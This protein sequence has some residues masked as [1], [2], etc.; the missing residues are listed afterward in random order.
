MINTIVIDDHKAFN[1]GLC[2][3]LKES[4]RFKVVEQ[5]YDSRDAYA[6]CFSLRPALVLL[7]YSMPY[8]NGL[9]VTKQ[10]KS[11]HYDCKVVII[12]MY[13]DQKEL[14]LLRDAGIDGYLTK[15]TSSDKLF[16]S[17]NRILAGEQLFLTHN[18]EKAAIKKDSL[19]ERP[20]LTKREIQV[21]KLMEENYTTTQIASALALSVYTIEI[22]Q[23]NILQKISITTTKESQL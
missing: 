10:I 9:E 7:D 12:S 4:Q 8:L 5:V 17:L 14:T 11:L 18:F 13:T 23:K 15:P 20:I 1:D 3:I 2:L 6:K 21:Q 19:G 22:L 16:N